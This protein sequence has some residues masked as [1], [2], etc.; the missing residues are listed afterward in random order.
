MLQVSDEVG[1]IVILLQPEKRHA[2]AGDNG[3][4]IADVA[5]ESFLRPDDA[6]TFARVGIIVAR[7]AAD[8]AP[9]KT[10]EFGAVLVAGAE[11]HRVARRTYP[12]DDGAG[13]G[14]PGAHGAGE[15]RT[16]LGEPFCNIALDR[17]GGGDVRVSPGPVSFLL[18]RQTA[19]VQGAGQ[20]G[21]ELEGGAVVGNGVVQPAELQE[22]EAAA[23]KSIWIVWLETQGLIAIAEGLPQVARERR[24]RPAAVVGRARSLSS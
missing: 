3:S 22:D 18:L 7:H 13:G 16:P 10:I 5:A 6:G 11:T 2:G 15:W 9:E 4:W 21:F 17:P 20:F 14:I 12:E 19:P 23:I 1:D 24:E 8:G